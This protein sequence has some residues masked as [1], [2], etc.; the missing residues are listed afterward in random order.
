MTS[1]KQIPEMISPRPAV[2]HHLQLLF[3]GQLTY[4]VIR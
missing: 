2:C 4:G 1:I 3:T